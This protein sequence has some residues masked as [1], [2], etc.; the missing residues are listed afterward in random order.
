MAAPA[1]AQSAASAGPPDAFFHLVVRDLDPVFAEIDELRATLR[2]LGL[3]DEGFAALSELSKTELGVDLVSAKAVT[4][5]G[6]DLSRGA[7]LFFGGGAD[8]EATVVLGV[9]E[10]S[11]FVSTVSRLIELTSGRKPKVKKQ[12]QG[13]GT[14]VEWSNEDGGVEVAAHLR[15][16]LATMG[17]PAALGYAVAGGAGAGPVTPFPDAGAGIDIGMW[18]DVARLAALTQDADVQ[19]FAQVVTEGWIRAT[20]GTDGLRVDGRVSLTGSGRELVA[21]M[22]PKYSDAAKQGA[23][24]NEMLTPPVALFRAMLP[25]R[26]MASLLEREGALTPEVIEEVRK[27]EGIDLRADIFDLFLGD[28]TFVM[29]TGAADMR[30]EF[31]VSDP[32]RAEKLVNTLWSR[33]AAPQYEGATSDTRVE[34]IRANEG[35]FITR[36]L[37]DDW[38]EFFVPTVH[39]GFRGGRLILGLAPAALSAPSSGGPSFVSSSDLEAVRRQLNK[40]SALFFYTAEGDPFSGMQDLWALIRAQ[41]GRKAAPFSDLIDVYLV[42]LALTRE[43]VTVAELDEQGLGISSE[44]RALRL[45]RSDGPD[46]PS[47]AYAA[48]LR[49]LFGGRPEV[50]RRAWSDVAARYPDS[51]EGKRAERALH[52]A[53]SLV[54]LY[55]GFVLGG[56]FMFSQ[57]AARSEAPVVLPAEPQGATPCEALA[58]RL[59]WENGDSDSRCVQARKRLAKKAGPTQREQEKCA[60]ELFR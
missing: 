18:V 46:T 35:H 2:W 31:A 30:L 55:N 34:T 3:G 32:A 33:I 44:L 15:G 54:W 9:S 29:P 57:V 10:E 5:A 23:V 6:F 58:N 17:P 39:W 53:N 11:A 16:G 26:A 1:Q 38:A 28:I 52:S 41:L 27:R 7:A 43:S 45:G 14:T 13:S 48:S 59:C 42:H 40:P 60:Y 24:F 19:A 37:T 20:E 21:S 56:F 8:P 51:P 50:A 12:K 36:F 47:G 25:L 22:A 4:A 49:M